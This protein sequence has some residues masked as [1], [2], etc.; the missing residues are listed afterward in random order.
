MISGVGSPDMGSNG[1]FKP[2]FVGIPIAKVIP[3]FQFRIIAVGGKGKGCAVWPSSHHFASE[4]DGF[5]PAFSF[6]QKERPKFANLL[7]HLPK[8]QIQ[9]GRASCRE[10]G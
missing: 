6:S 1:A 10:R 4:P 8:D 5:F 9:I 3:F 2:V 7:M